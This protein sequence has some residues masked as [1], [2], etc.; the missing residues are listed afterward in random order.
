MKV[1]NMYNGVMTYARGYVKAPVAFYDG[2]VDCQHCPCC[3]YDRYFGFYRCKLND[4]FPALMP[5]ITISQEQLQ[6]RPD[7][8]PVQIENKEE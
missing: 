8:C 1:M 4:Y 3:W 2:I 7:A 6:T 5:N